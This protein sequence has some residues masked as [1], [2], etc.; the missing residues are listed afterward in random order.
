MNSLTQL[1]IVHK[2]LMRTRDPI[3]AKHSQRFFKTGKGQYAEGDLFLGIPVPVLRKIS[4]EFQHLSHKE[5]IALLH[6]SWHEERLLAL[7]VLVFQFQKGS[8]SNREIIAKLYLHE[9]RYI[10]NWDLVDTSAD[11]ILGEFYLDKSIDPLLHLARSKNLWERRMAI[12][13]TFAF[14]RKGSYEATI[15][16][17][18]I[19]LTDS[20]DLIH[21]ATGWM[22]REVGKRALAVEET[23]LMK[24]FRE[25]PRTMLRYAIEKFPEAKRQKYLLHT[26]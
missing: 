2:R 25:M 11:K 16:I 13:A 14:I 20:H 23:Y 19:L 8:F 18:E 9:T 15:T 7:Y 17:A 1:D 21:K 3:R 10:N 4:R 6:S 24:Y 12:I 5:I 26:I 22:L